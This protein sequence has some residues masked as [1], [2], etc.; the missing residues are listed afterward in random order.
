MIEKNFKKE[1]QLD[2]YLLRNGNIT[3]VEYVKL[4]GVK[5]AFK[6][7]KSQ[8]WECSFWLEGDW[9]ECCV[10]HDHGC[11]IAKIAKSKK[12]RKV[13]DKHLKECVQKSDKGV[14]HKA[15]R[16]GMG[17][18]MYLGVRGLATYRKIKG[19]PGY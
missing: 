1:M 14:L 18:L 8:D 16:W 13:T 5:E 9:L 7:W 6:L 2:E 10:K 17:N 3:M 11:N 12:F 19:E 4:V 15:F